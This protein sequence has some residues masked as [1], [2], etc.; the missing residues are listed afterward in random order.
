M[1]V[2]FSF[3]VTARSFFNGYCCPHLSHM[4]IECLPDE[5]L[6]GIIYTSCYGARSA[7]GLYLYP[8][9]PLT[10]IVVRIPA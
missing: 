7:L 5:N 9:Q 10:A 1:L 2:F 8:R 4:A 6:L 3:I